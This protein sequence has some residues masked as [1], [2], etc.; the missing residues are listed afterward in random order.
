M[1]AL[2]LWLAV[3]P[4]IREALVIED[5][6]GISGGQAAPLHG[7]GHELVSRSQQVLFG[8]LTVVVVGIAVGV[9]FAVVF[10]KARHRLPGSTDFGRSLVLAGIGF[11]AVTLFPAIAV[12]ANPPAVGDPATVG[13]RT[14][15]YVL[16]ILVAVAIALA[17]PAFDRWLA[18][19]GVRDANRWAVDVLVA[20][21]AAAVALSVLPGSPDTVPPDVPATLLWDF[22]IASLGQF[23]V[24]WL[25]LGTIFGVLMDR[26]ST[27]ARTAR[28]AEPSRAR[29]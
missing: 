21:L 22:R 3:E 11:G 8:A 7:G 10:A 1:A 15:D 29:A 24:L 27:N 6:R 17:V 2:V 25:G 28:A 19:R 12:P 23:V 9:V 4:V 16:S 26:G 14:A 20:V 18:G 13:D 5:A